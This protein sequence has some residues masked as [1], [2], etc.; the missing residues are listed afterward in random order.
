MRACSDHAATQCH[1]T[2]RPI[3]VNSLDKPRPKHVGSCI[4]LEIDGV[5]V[6]STA[7]HTADW[8]RKGIQL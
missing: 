8:T 4:L 5:R 1:K 2:A 6:L 3:Y 7:A